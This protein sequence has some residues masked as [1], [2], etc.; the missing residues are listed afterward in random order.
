MQTSLIL[1][2]PV[3][4]YLILSNPA[5]GTCSARILSRQNMEPDQGSN[6][7]EWF[8]FIAAIEVLVVDEPPDVREGKE[9]WNYCVGASFFVQVVG[10]I[11]SLTRSFLSS[12]NSI[13]LN[14]QPNNKQGH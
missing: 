10:H 13:R 4:S 9:C 7:P 12:Y 2:D 8:D 6:F 11:A 5:T 3:Q 14:E 1:P